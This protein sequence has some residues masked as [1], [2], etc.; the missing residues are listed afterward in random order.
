MWEMLNIIGSGEI[1][2]ILPAVLQEQLG[3]GRTL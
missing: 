3:T 2:H 1:I